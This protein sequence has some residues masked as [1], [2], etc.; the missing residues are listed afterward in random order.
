MTEHLHIVTPEI[1]YPANA[2]ILSDVFFMLKALS[3]SGVKIHLHCFSDPSVNKG[4]LEEYCANIH[5]YDRD[6]TKISFK[7][8]LPYNVSTRANQKLCDKLNEDDYPVLFLGLNTTY[9]IYSNQIDT[10]RKVA[11]RYNRNESNYY[12]DLAAI[13]PWRGKK[14]HYQIES[15]RFKNYLKKIVAEKITCFA[16]D[17]LSTLISTPRKEASVIPL[18]IFTGFPGLFH[19]QGKGNFCLFH[20]RLSDR[21]T[22]YAA[23][24]LLEHVFNTVE[25][26]FV[27]AGS[28]PSPELERAAHVRNHTCLVSDPGEKEMMELIKKAQVVVSP[29]FIQIEDPEH[30]IQS[31]SLGRHVLINPKSTKDK[32]ARA[33]SH[34]AKTPEEFIEKTQLLFETEFTEEEKFSRQ[35]FLHEKYQDET[36]LSQLLKWLS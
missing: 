7:I 33:I 35:P 11:V 34:L 17:K 5:F 24:W 18:P 12:Q 1:P 23:L 28:N 2:P 31:L 26:P 15:W 21:E 6:L 36:G 13:V 16:T 8:D 4:N 20:G 27:I 30:L 29:S 14:M 3:E 10:K 19:H 9:S 22:E 32:K 25:I